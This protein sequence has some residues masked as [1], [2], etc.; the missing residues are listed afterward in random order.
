KRENVGDCRSST[1]SH[2]FAFLKDVAEPK[3]NLTQVQTCS[4]CATMCSFA[5]EEAVAQS[6]LIPA[7]WPRRSSLGICCTMERPASQTAL[8]I[9][10][11]RLAQHQ[12]SNCPVL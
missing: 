10:L 7:T 1:L 5:E 11:H 9:R 3:R 2:H 12:Y 4:Y 8:L 6:C